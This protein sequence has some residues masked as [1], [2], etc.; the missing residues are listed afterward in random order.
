MLWEVPRVGT[1]LPL[2]DRPC[3]NHGRHN[4]AS[5]FVYLETNCCAKNETEECLIFPVGIH[6]VSDNLV[7]YF[8]KEWLAKETI[9]MG[10]YFVNIEHSNNVGD[11]IGFLC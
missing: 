9:M 1:W 11:E 3:G 6:N 8:V 10:D 4:G 5:Q 7:Y 2:A